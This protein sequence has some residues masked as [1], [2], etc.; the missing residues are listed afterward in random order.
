[1][2]KKPPVRPGIT[3]EVGARVEAQDYLQKW[4][5]SRIEKIDYERGKMLVHFDRWSHR[6]DEWIFWDSDRLRP[7]EKPMSHKV[8]QN[9]K[10]EASESL[11]EITASRFD[12]LPGSSESTEDQT[13]LQQRQNFKD[14]EEVLARWT[15]CR[16]YPAKIETIHDDGT[17]TVQF[18]DGVIRCV[19]RIHI[20]SMPEDAKGQDWIALVKAATDAAK[21]KGG[22]RP[23]T[24]AN[25]K[26]KE[27]RK[28]GAVTGRCESEAEDDLEIVEDPAPD[29][30]KSV[31]LTA[32]V[33]DSSLSQEKLEMPKTKRRKTR[34]RSSFFTRR[35]R[36]RKKTASKATS[37]ESPQCK[38]EQKGQAALPDGFYSPLDGAHEPKSPA[39]SAQ[40]PAA[41]GHVSRL[42]SPPVSR[43]I[44]LKQD[45]VESD[46]S[47]T[48]TSLS[49]GPGYMEREAVSGSPD[50][51]VQQ[52]GPVA[53]VPDARRTSESRRRS[54]RLA[55]F[56]PSISFRQTCTSPPSQEEGCQEP[57][58]CQAS[59]AESESQGP[60]FMQRCTSP[61]H[62]PGV[63]LPSEASSPSALPFPPHQLPI[64]TCDKS[65]DADVSNHVIPEEQTASLTADSGLK[66]AART[67][68]PNKHTREPIINMKRSDGSTSPKELLMDLDHNKFR[69]RI[70]GCGKAFRKAKLLDYH[71]KYYHNADKEAESEAGSPEGAGRARAASASMPT[72]SLLD[73]VGSKR[74]RTVS[75]S[76]SLSPQGSTFQ[77]DSS[78]S[79]SKP[80][81]FRLIKTEKKIKLEEIQ[82][83]GKRK[84]KDKERKDKKEKFPFRI[85]QKK[86][87][88]KK[89]KS[90]QHIY[91]DFE[92]VSL[93]YM[94][95]CS[96]PLN[97]SCS[98]SF[99][100][101]STPRH[102]PFQYP[103]AILSVDLTGENLSDMD[104]LADST[105]ESALLSGDE[106][107]AADSSD[108]EPAMAE[109][110]EYA[111]DIVRC[112][113]EMD[114]EN[115]FMIQCEECMCWQ[116]SV[117]MGLLE[118]CIPDQYV[119]YV[120]QDPPGQR[121]SAKYRHDKDWMTKGHMYGLSFLAEN[122][123]HSNA[124][125]IVSTHQL[126]ADVYSVSKVLHGLH[127][128]MDILQN[129]HNP[130]LHLWTRSWVRSGEDSVMDGLQDHV[131]LQAPSAH[132]DTYITSEHSY[133]KPPGP[134]PRCDRDAGMWPGQGALLPAELIP[135]M[136]SH[137]VQ[138]VVKEEEELTVI[139]VPGFLN[140]NFSEDSTG[141]VQN[142]LQWQLNL[143]AHIEDVQSQL[144]GRMDLIEKELDV[145]ESW[146]DFTGELE[147]PDP[148]ARLPQLKRRVKQLL[149]DLEK[150]QQISALCSV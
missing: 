106:Y 73:P 6:Y 107:R 23:R 49:A 77:F 84:D 29:A 16:Y 3:F 138:S 148:L 118:D 65:T 120:C 108:L 75:S 40:C 12:E 7:L 112:I 54:Q 105:T 87:K 59:S 97:H 60:S 71:L 58:H 114:E 91:E 9:D 31:A 80:P 66:V 124:E 111:G 61:P 113:C 72:S 21:G 22:S 43:E 18:Y 11:S 92:D 4:Y 103:R 74:R 17:Y 46:R 147:P 109:E 134:G 30:G 39:G 69:C 62:D 42:P 64:A 57:K 88:K 130:N 149:T 51:L 127:L 104:S 131:H 123:S 41:Q 34:Q 37:E 67:L 26:A 146:L 96:S 24:T 145:L 81:K 128:K 102:T 142:C 140:E 35:P 133:Q 79:Y 13:E 78:E 125:K 48:Q 89:K 52:G 129:K 56:T 15:D 95:R 45:S 68:K 94:R 93:A 50:S 136:V 143:L 116:H 10:E 38:E 47:Q 5:P 132:M 55:P 101:H 76:S 98:T 36:H 20:K 8:G 122:Y 90:K 2:S 44:E 85:K 14:G 82:T 115:G 126:M 53:T 19:K 141:Q 70:P 121:L 99:R 137:T 150:V 119:C 83:I 33:E 110:E 139:S 144:A 100:L 117:C 86:K 1:M 28:T 135:H 32:V 27:T 25:S 63:H